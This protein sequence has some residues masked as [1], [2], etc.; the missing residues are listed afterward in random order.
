[1]SAIVPQRTAGAA[2]VRASV[3]IP[4]SNSAA[5]VGQTLASVIAQTLEDIEI[6]VVDDGST[7][8]TV[9]VVTANMAADPHGRIRLVRQ[10][11]A[12]T[13]AARNRG[14][15]EA[16]GR[17][18][19]PLDADDLIAPTMLEECAALLDADPG[20]ALI[21]PDREDFGDVEGVRVA[22]EYELRRLRYFNQLPYCS[23]FRKTLWQAIGGYRINV[24][25]FD[26]WDFWV[27]AAMRGFRGR[28][29]G[30]P[31][32]RHRRHG[33]S[34]LWRLIGDYER[35][36]ARIILNNVAAYSAAEVAMAERYL[37]GGEPAPVLRSAK[38][39]F[40][41]GYYDGYPP[42]R[43]APP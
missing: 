24:S 26:D 12:G 8:D 38:F 9:A 32:L 39:L 30:K 37:E 1:V 29:L 33:D 21:Y 35:L 3:V 36:H 5:F 28:H 27:A 18:I 41:A 10:P 22:G 19:L 2:T 16:Q 11:N 15:A 40:L 6:V 42:R 4:C 31:F 13:A 14:I 17:Y 43:G 20:L 25:G 23:L 7:D 34:Q